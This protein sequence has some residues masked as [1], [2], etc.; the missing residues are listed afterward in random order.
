MVY[1]DLMGFNGIEWD[2]TIWKIVT[3]LLK[4]TMEIVSF[5]IENGDFPYLCQFTRGYGDLN[6]I[7]QNDEAKW[8]KIPPWGGLNQATEMGI[9]LIQPTDLGLE[10]YEKLDN[11]H[12]T[13]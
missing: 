5:P 10:K 11:T 4:V 6:L 7:Q 13:W 8:V 2:S 1:W 9:Q 12:E 3:Q